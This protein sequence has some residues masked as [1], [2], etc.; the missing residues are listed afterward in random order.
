M[1]TITKIE[2]R[3]TPWHKGKLLGHHSTAVGH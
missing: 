3:A 2:G 1:G